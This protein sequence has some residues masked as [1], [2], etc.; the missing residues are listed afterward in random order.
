MNNS[1]LINLKSKITILYVSLF[2]LFVISWFGTLNIEHWIIVGLYNSCFWFSESTRKFILAFSAFVIFGILYDLM[3]LYPNYKVSPVDIEGI[4]NFEKLL[5]GIKT[6]GH[7]YIPLEYIANYQNKVLDFLM[8]IFYINWVPV[9]LAFAFWLYKKDKRQFLNF[10]LTFLLVNLI[11]FSFYYIHP[12]APPWY[13]EKHGFILNLNIHGDTAG[14]ENFDKLINFPLFASIYSRNSN[15]FAAIPSLHCAYPVI[16]LYFAFKSQMKQA[17]WLLV[18]FMLGIW[19]A[20]VYSGHHY[21]IDVVFGI[22]CAVFGIWIFRKLLK[23]K[24]FVKFM[25]KNESHI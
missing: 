4:Y 12:A 1:F 20:A 23:I 11:G 3:K 6:G 13:V 16:V 17:I 25:N 7:V 5:F 10:S 15:V 2:Y 9:P 19:F 14:L 18:I 8:G 22:I 21:I 24:L